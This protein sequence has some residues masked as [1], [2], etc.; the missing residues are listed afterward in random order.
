MKK[1]VTPTVLGEAGCHMVQTVP[2]RL[3][4]EIAHQRANCQVRDFC[5]ETACPDYQ[6]G[7]CQVLANVAE[8]FQTVH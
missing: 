5:T 4:L 1:A 6:N 8:E 7:A 2:T 3:V